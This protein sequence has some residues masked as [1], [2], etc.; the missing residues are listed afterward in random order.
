VFFFSPYSIVTQIDSQSLSIVDRFVSKGNHPIPSIEEN[1][2][3]RYKK[4]KEREKMARKRS[5]K[6]NTNKKLTSNRD[7]PV[8]SSTSSYSRQ[9]DTMLCAQCS[10]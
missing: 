4:K 9:L 8:G 6:I 3:R 1:N 10:E 7:Q 5:L 2:H